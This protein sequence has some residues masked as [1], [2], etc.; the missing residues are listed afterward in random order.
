MLEIFYV[1]IKVHGI[2]QARILEWVAISFSSGWFPALQAD[3]L[4]SEPPGKPQGK[5]LWGYWNGHINS[6]GIRNNEKFSYTRAFQFM[7]NNGYQMALV[8]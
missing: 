4:P 5:I 7:N 8:F 1:K 2:F 6:K 3:A